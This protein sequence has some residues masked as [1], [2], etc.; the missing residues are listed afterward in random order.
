VQITPAVQEH[1]DDAHLL[2]PW[3]GLLMLAMLAWW[4]WHR[5]AVTRVRN[6]GLVRAATIAGPIVLAVL[7]VG[8]LIEVVLIGHAGA[9]AAWQG[10]G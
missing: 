10:R 3:M 6:A 2:L 7:A 4:A 8:T 5:F 9:A 1:V